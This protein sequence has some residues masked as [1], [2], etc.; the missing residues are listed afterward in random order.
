MNI[1]TNPQYTMKQ[2]YFLILL[3]MC[4]V[5][6]PMDANAGKHKRLSDEEAALI[7]NAKMKMMQEEL[8]LTDEQTNQ[9]IPLYRSYLQDLN[10]V[11]RSRKYGHRAK[12]TTP[13][14][15]AKIITDRLDINEK[16]IK[17]QKE[18]IV[19]FSQIL[20]ADQT[21]RIFQVERTI[22]RKIRDE[23]KR[24]MNSPRACII[25]EYCCPAESTCCHA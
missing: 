5:A 14:E 20:N 10:N 7:F 11:F 17:L 15:A 1:K 16:V 6:S 8:K 24:R 25:H 9:L 2:I 13:E 19:K 4:L 23:K 21:M 22:Q 12:A 3:A 18:Y